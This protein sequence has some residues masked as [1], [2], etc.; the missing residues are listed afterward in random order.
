VIRKNKEEILNKLLLRLKSNTDITD[1][2]PGSI[3]RAFSEVLS[4]EFYQFYTELD[5]FTTMGFVSTAGGNFLDLI[6][7]LLNCTRVSG[8]TDANY[9]SRIVNQVYVI[10]GANYTSIRLKALSV[11]GV[12]NIITREFTNG[13]GSFTLYVVTDDPVTSSAILNEVEDVVEAS[14]AYGILAEIKT[15]TLILTDLKVR[16]VF[17]DKVSDAEKATIRQAATQSVKAYMD[18]IEVG[19][20]FIMNEAIKAA[21]NTSTKITDV[22]VLN[23]KTDGIAQFIKNI[24]ADWYE[25][26]VIGTLEVA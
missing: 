24:E 21:M 26:I 19:G 15:P 6:G 11:N 5:L 25:R 18:G 20:S 2:D 7:A 12:K 3:A 14:K 10:Q 9:R 1:V 16:L 13:T 4:E 22:S 17:S 23:F 8:E